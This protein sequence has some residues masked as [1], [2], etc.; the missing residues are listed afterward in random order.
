MYIKLP[1][2]K[3]RLTNDGTLELFFIGT[4]FA[5]ARTLFQT[6]FF[7]VKGD[8][9]ILVDFGSTGP[10]ALAAVGIEPTDISVFLPTH[11]HCDHIGGVEFLSLLNRYVGVSVLKKPKLRMIIN[12]EYQDILWNM[13]LR[14]GMEFNEVSAYGNRLTFDDYYDVARPTLKTTSP[15][16]TWE[17]DFNGIKIEIFRVN[18]IP[19]NSTSAGT[20]FITY[21]LFIDNRIM[22]SGDT[23]FDMS[24]IELY[25]DRAEY[26][27]HDASLSPN[28]VHASLSE[29]R[30]LPA[31]IKKKMFLMHYSD[32][33]RNF[34]VDDFA[35]YARQGER[36]IFD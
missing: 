27:F 2:G 20:A 33:W 28:P 29:L 18:H 8:T 24:L 12:E 9:H 36:Y 6:N 30:G 25:A 3:F 10:N 32:D 31:D 21:G 26:I 23:K 14:G 17:I 16:E 13:S 15:R 22:I 4:G 1:D 5:F 7:I 11:S 35:G 19:G 34:P